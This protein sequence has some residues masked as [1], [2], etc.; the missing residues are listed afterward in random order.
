[1]KSLS[2]AS[3]GRPVIEVTRFRVRNGV[4]T[5]G[6]SA[7]VYEGNVMLSL[8]HGTKMVARHSC[9]A[10]TGGPERGEW[11]AEIALPKNADTVVVHQEVM[12]ETPAEFTA[13]EE[14]RIS[15]NAENV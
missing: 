6:G 1:M 14:V 2:L 15:L 11:V 12:E 9:Q 7:V 8:T 3:D 4:L 13:A 10:S 5:I